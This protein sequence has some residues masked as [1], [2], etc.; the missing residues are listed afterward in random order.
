M[1]HYQACSDSDQSPVLRVPYGK[2]LL[3]LPFLVLAVF[4]LKQGYLVMIALVVALTLAFLNRIGQ[5]QQADSISHVHK[6][7]TVIDGGLSTSAESDVAVSVNHN[8]VS[9]G[10]SFERA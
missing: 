2:Y 5:L 1:Q 8:V 6:K 4:E 9:D 10:G 3:L 7:H